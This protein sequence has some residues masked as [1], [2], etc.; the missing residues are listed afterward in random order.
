[1]S[2]YDPIALGVTVGLDAIRADAVPLIAR[3]NA[4]IE[5]D[6]DDDCYLV[7]DCTAVM[8]SPNDI[9]SWTL[10]PQRDGTWSH[11]MS[12]VSGTLGDCLAGIASCYEPRAYAGHPAADGLTHGISAALQVVAQ[13][14]AE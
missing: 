11:D 5:R 13:D 10:F 2:T 8:R 14:G 12:G 7:V 1:M 6:E 9:Q 3:I 4:S